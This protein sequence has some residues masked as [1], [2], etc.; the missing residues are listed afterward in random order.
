MALQLT[1]RDTLQSAKEAAWRALAH[2]FGA[3]DAPA[4]KLAALIRQGADQLALP[5]SG[6]TLARW[7]NLA[8]VASGDLGLAKLYEGHTDALAILAELQVLSP[9]ADDARWGVWCAEPPGERVEAAFESPT[10]TAQSGAEVR[11][12][13]HKPWCSGAQ[14][15]D[16]ALMSSWLADGQC[17]LVAV[18]MHQPGIR[19]DPSHWQAVGMASSA[20][21]DVHFEGV[22]G[23]LVGSPGQYLSRP[24]FVHGGAGVAACWYGAAARITS[25]LRAAAAPGNDAHR[26]AHLGALDVA[27]SSAASLM[28]EAAAQIDQTPTN[29]CLLAVQRARLAVEAAAEEVL[30]CVP[31]AVGAGPLCKNRHLAR[32]MAD[33]PVFMRQSHAERDQAALGALVA[34]LPEQSPWTL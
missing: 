8:E 2:S 25:Y 28:R 6:R 19:I 34:R 16:W 31:R 21:V 33:L 15:I 18:S 1:Q 17:C 4:D 12:S 7:R 23:T 5:G 3:D 24:G 20:S 30:R 13:G 11:L 26:L 27:L 32:L 9:A 29:N 10:Q 22:K 14:S